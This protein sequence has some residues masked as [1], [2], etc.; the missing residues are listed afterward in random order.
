MSDTNQMWA[1]P[2]WRD[3]SLEEIWV[4]GDDMGGGEVLGIP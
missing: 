1:R 2:L 3:K 4:F